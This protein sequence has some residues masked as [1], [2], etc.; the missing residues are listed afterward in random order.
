MPLDHRDAPTPEPL[1]PLHC[2][3]ALQ[4]GPPTRTALPTGTPVWLVRRHADVR[5]VLTDPR[6]GRAELFAPDA[7]KLTES[8]NLTDEPNGILN[9][10]G[11]EHQRLRRTV[12]RAF[13]P[14]A[15]ARWRPWVASVVEDLLT[16][17]GKAEPPVDLVASFTR[18]LPVAVISRLMDL[19]GLN[20]ERLAHWSDQ[21]LS[22]SAYTPQEV[23]TGMRE[24]GEFAAQLVAERRRSPGEDL[25]SSLVQAADQDGE[26][27]EQQIVPLVMGLVVAGHETT[28]T[29]LGNA[30][31][32]LLGEDL[33]TWQ[34]LAGDEQQAA[35][36]AEQLLRSVPLGDRTVLP[37]LLRRAVADVEIGG[38]LIS[39][40]D[41]VAAD[42]FAANHDPETYPGDWRA[43]LLSQPSTPHLTFGAGPHH[44][45]GA[46]LARMELE[47]ALNRLAQRLPQLRLAVPV[48]RITWRTGLLTRS[49]QTLPVTW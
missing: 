16:G 40:G 2:L 10:D 9:L 14:R 46:W 23:T 41:V 36:V 26:V 13:T 32:Y 49:P 8:P 39:A 42:T 28:I 29:A 25:V 17:L 33:R 19:D 47:L 4:P 24:F 7:P 44:C 5:Q 31:V 11:P 1:V 38:V 30:L 34:E 43:S 3:R 12:Q 45:L 21:A 35:T 20:F 27:T 22:T 15:V 18:P 37:G 48:D 6:L